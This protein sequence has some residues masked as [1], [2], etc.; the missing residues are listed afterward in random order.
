MTGKIHMYTGPMFSGKTSE[1]MR[2]F[3]VLR[4]GL[5][6]KSDAKPIL[7]LR[8]SKDNRYSEDSAATHDGKML[9]DCENVIPIRD[10]SEI[11]EKARPCS[12]IFIDEGQLFE[13]LKDTC[14]RW[15]KEGKTVVISCLDAHSDHPEH[16]PWKEIQS[17][18]PYASKVVKLTVRHDLISFQVLD[19]THAMKTGEMLRMRR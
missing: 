18:L 2:Q 9:K 12:H 16:S 4:L 13:G 10:L 7:F 17:L 11:T 3:T 19:S 6:K 8:N 1:I 15:A 5:S 14:I